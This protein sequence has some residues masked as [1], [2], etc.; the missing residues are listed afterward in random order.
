MS[1]RSRDHLE[2]TLRE[3]TT[4]RAS[5]GELMCWSMEHA[6]SAEEI[7]ECIAESLS[8]L[9]T[10]IYKKVFTLHSLAFSVCQSF[11]LS[12]NINL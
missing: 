5:V 10:P 3:L 2:D 9:E 11:H 6:E 12:V 8:L 4:S 7:V 1:D